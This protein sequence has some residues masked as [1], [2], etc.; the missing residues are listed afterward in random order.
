MDLNFGV[1]SIMSQC[2][3]IVHKKMHV[4]LQSTLMFSIL[5]T[6]AND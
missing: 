3:Y 4:C 2:T 5:I 1:A 6:N